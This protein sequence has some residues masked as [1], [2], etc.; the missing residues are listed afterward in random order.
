LYAIEPVIPLS[1]RQPYSKKKRKEKNMIRT[2]K[3]RPNLKRIEL[4]FTNSTELVLDDPLPDRIDLARCLSHLS[5]SSFSLS[6]LLCASE[7]D[8][9]FSLLQILFSFLL[10]RR[11]CRF[12]FF[13]VV[14]DCPL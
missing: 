13:E 6:L 8:A 14:G 10:S 12:F 3:N 5:P 11:F 9:L 4:S 1:H 2:G 7:S